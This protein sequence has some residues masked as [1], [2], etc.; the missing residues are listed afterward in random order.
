MADRANEIR[1]LREKANQFRGLAQT[2]EGEV[3]LKLLD[4][5]EEIGALADALEK[6]SAH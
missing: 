1:Y 3:A 6:G 2:S 5:A 4:I